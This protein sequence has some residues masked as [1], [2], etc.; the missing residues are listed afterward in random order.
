[1]FLVLF[2]FA[3]PA[4]KFIAQHFPDKGLL[5]VRQ[6]RQ[7]VIDIVK[8][9]MADRRLEIENEQ[10]SLRLPFRLTSCFSCLCLTFQCST[11][12]PLAPFSCYLLVQEKKRGGCGEEWEA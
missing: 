5:R 11:E 2:P 9:L 1:M 7:V 6:G 3:A 8:R 10:A 4:I 12:L